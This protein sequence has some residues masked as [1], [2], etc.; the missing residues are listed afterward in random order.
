[1]KSWLKIPLNSDFPLENLPFGIAEIANGKTIAVTRIG[2]QI[3]DL[4]KLQ[5]S[6]IFNDL[7]FD[8]EGKFSQSVLNDFIGMDKKAHRAIREKLQEIFSDS[9]LSFPEKI[10]I[11]RAHV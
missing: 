1:M 9:N 8:F 6:G 11:G 5:Q 7:G 3:I 4:E 2:D 10:K